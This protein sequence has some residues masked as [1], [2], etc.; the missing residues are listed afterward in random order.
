M[1]CATV[2]MNNSLEITLKPNPRT[3]KKRTKGLRGWSDSEDESSVAQPSPP[4]ESPA[5]PLPSPPASPPMDDEDKLVAAMLLRTARSKVEQAE[6]SGLSGYLDDSKLGKTVNKRL[7]KGEVSQARSFN[8][9]AGVVPLP[10]DCAERAE[11]DVSREVRALER[12]YLR[13]AH[14]MREQAAAAE[15]SDAVGGLGRKRQRVGGQGAA[16][17]MAAVEEEEARIAAEDDELANPLMRGPAGQR[18][19][20]KK[21]SLLRLGSHGSNSSGGADRDVL[22]PGEV[23]LPG[24]PDLHKEA[25]DDLWPSKGMRVRVVDE[26]GEF[27]VGHLKKGVVRKRHTQIGAVDVELD[28][29]KS[30]GKVGGG[31]LLRAVPQK[32]LETV[33]TKT[34]KRIEVVRGT[35]KGVIAELLSRDSRQNSATVRIGRGLSIEE[36][37]L[38]LDNICEFV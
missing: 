13:S 19:L 6:E 18:K 17:D 5:S 28:D 38:P 23:R 12:E 15:S 10:A 22:L 25:G 20:S 34:C 21:P 2:K 7:L 3:M 8:R 14:Q 16:V 35:H 36:L 9:R 33:V 4:P 24:P 26:K 32:L 30:E 27:K 1:S 31:R 11:T 37:R 29:A